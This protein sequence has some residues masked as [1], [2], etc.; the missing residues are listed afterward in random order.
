LTFL[1]YERQDGSYGARNYVLVIP[2][3][4]IA[5]EICH[6]VAG[7]KTIVTPMDPTSGRTKE[8]RETIARAY[9]GLGQNPN[10]ASVLLVPGGGAGGTQYPETTVERLAGEISRSGKR[11]EVLKDDG[12]DTM[13]AIARGVRLAREM[14]YE[15][16]K[17][18]RKPCSD[19]YLCLGVKCGNS[20]P[21]SGMAGN[22][23]VG[24]VYDKLVEAEGTVLFG[25]TTEIIGAEHVL[26]RRAVSE[27]VAREILR[28]AREIEER[29]KFT[30]QDIRTI[31][32]VPANIKAGITTLEEKSLGAIY[33]AGTKPIQGVL[34]YA[35]R[36]RGSGLYFVDNWAWTLSI[37]MGYAAAGAQIVLY[38]LGG[39][40]LEGNSV[41]YQTGSTVAPLIWC[42]ANPR[43]QAVGG[44]NLDF[45]SGT[46]I[47][48]KETIADVGERLYAT[49][50]DV[51]S[52]TLTRTETLNHTDPNE[53]YTREPV[54]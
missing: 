52:G 21:T 9:I 34:K 23:V 26:A 15:A 20:D 30:G 14:V 53:V 47:E 24:Y 6:F 13:V 42:S 37:F 46:I 8:D 22:P 45:Y 16:S 36:P 33:K 11:V 40:G 17:L 49:I 32:P 25:E 28:V 38:Q 19:R 44:W 12:G 35:E 43:T 31:N 50:L 51:A 4:I 29:S 7:T 54:F 48:G 1:G 18:R 10:V 2:S 5:D 39:G 27:V 3:G 41:F